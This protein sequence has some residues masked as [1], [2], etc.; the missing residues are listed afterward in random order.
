MQSQCHYDLNFDESTVKVSVRTAKKL[1]Q[2][3]DKITKLRN[4][5]NF[6]RFFDL[7]SIFWIKSCGKA[8]L[9]TRMNVIRF[10]LGV[11]CGRIKA[12]QAGRS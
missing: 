10:D 5:P 12:E 8:A 4:M 7:S 3:L 6:V 11:E 2:N 1:S 9:F